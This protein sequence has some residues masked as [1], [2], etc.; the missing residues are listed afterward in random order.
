MTASTETNAHGNSSINI[1]SS[2]SNSRHTSSFSGSS[3]GASGSHD[4]T[5]SNCSVAR[6][7]GTTGWKH[8]E[9]MDVTDTTTD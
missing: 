1:R 5:G 3:L 8:E 4:G 2:T 6:D 9:S 7:G